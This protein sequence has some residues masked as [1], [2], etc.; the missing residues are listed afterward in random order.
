MKT[1]GLGDLAYYIFRPVVY[2]IDAVWDTDLKDCDR[3]KERRKAWN[4][5][6]SVT[7]PFLFTFLVTSLAALICWVM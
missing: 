3:C 6:L 5:K 1:F 4:A 7:H 2:L